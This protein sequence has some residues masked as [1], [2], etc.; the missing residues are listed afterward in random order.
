MA[1]S[2][3]LVH[4]ANQYLI[5][6]GY[7]NR[8]GISDIIGSEASG[9]GM[10]GVLAIHAR[11]SVPLNLHISGTL[12]EAIA[13]HCPH[14]LTR[15]REYLNAGLVEIIGSCY[16]QNIMRFFS[17]EYNRR[18]LN[19]ELRLFRDLLNIDPCSVKVFWPPERVWDTRRMAPILRDA[20]LLNDGYR[21]VILDDR[22]LLSTRDR[23]L[24]R[25]LFDRGD[26]WTPDL[27]RACEIENGLGL[28]ALPIATRLRRSIPPKQD[29]DWR[30]VRTELESLLVHAAD[31][32]EDN[33]LA[34]YADDMEKVIGVWGPD[35]PP[36]YAEFLEWVTTSAWI[37]PVKL[38]GWTTANPP[39]QPRRV[40]NGTF[41]E[42]A[43]EFDAGEAYENWYHSEHWAPYREHFEWAERRVRECKKSGDPAL[44]ELAEK[45]LL[46]SNWETAWHTP[47]TGAHGDPEDHGKPSPWARALTSHSRHA[48]VTAE[49]ACWKLEHDGRAHAGIRDADH[50]GEPDL[51]IANNAL[52]GL[53]TSR[54]GGRL[55]SLYSVSGDRGAMVVGNPCD[56][57][58]FLEDLNRFMTTPR[59][60]PGA[61]ADV[62]FESDE[63]SCEILEQGDEALVRLI[64][65]QQ[66]SAAR[67][68]I[69]T[70][71]FTASHTSLTVAYRLPETLDRLSVECA[72]SPDYL[73][74]L[75]RGSTELVCTTNGCAMG[76][77]QI[78]LEPSP[79]A[80]FE[81]APQC[82]A[83]ARTFRIA[84]SQ[85]DFQVTLR[86]E[87]L[88]G[89]D[90]R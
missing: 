41:V 57:W 28:I 82:A 84:S 42:L 39:A 1:T 75:R 62:D 22:T 46:V 38:T 14:F 83:H 63:Y 29:D 8:E 24:P 73:Q 21:Y 71:R 26:H 19:E 51:I 85:R 12:L 27:F 80:A 36:R 53:V 58:N 61:F 52:F 13:W 66:D 67:G 64:N 45:Q 72:L 10:L 68:L 77:V 3:A 47:A 5:T 88:P 50:D 69:K 90:S 74:L 2:L 59:N 11:Y 37:A 70:Y 44:I 76:Q 33:L 15:L 40:E 89:P 32:G 79:G 78:V 34:L 16:G 30:C 55:V 6:D 35:G 17:P 7:E 9:A 81:P 48:A 31:V 65:V 56:D 25:A 20:S 87:Q 86:V 18:Q 23:S 4:H 54:W 49:A 43:R 60:H